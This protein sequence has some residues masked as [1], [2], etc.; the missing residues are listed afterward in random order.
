MA[1]QVIKSE[2]VVCFKIGKEEF[3]VDILL[4]QEIFKLPE[5]TKLPKAADYVIGVINLRGKVIPIVDLSLKFGLGDSSVEKHAHGTRGLVV[6]IEGKQVA[7]AIDSVSHV[8]RVTSSDIEPPPPVIRGISGRY[9]VGIAKIDAGFVVILDIST[10][11]S[12][13]EISVL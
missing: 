10:L 2:Q 3:A 9:I 5:I 12:S 1:T 6:S 7:L 8:V 4:V 13:E 11:F